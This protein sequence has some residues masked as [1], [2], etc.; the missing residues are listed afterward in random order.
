MPVV[1]TVTQSGAAVTVTSTNSGG[2][3]ST[4]LSA[5][6]VAGIVIGTFLG[7]VLLIA[8]VL[9]LLNRYSRHK[10]TRVANSAHDRVSP[11]AGAPD[12]RHLPGASPRKT[13]HFTR[14]A[15]RPSMSSEPLISPISWPPLPSTS[16]VQSPGTPRSAD[17]I[18]PG[19]RDSQYSSYDLGEITQVIASGTVSHP[20]VPAILN[21]PPA[22]K[23]GQT[24]SGS[25]RSGLGDTPL[26]ARQA[27]AGDIPGPF[28][29]QKPQSNLFIHRML[30][31]RAQASEGVPLPHSPSLDLSQSRSTTLDSAG[32]RVDE[33]RLLA[34]AER[35]ALRDAEIAQRNEDERM[36]DEEDDWEEVGT[37]ESI[38]S[39]LSAPIDHSAFFSEPEP[40]SC[41]NSSLSAPRRKSSRR[42]TRT[43]AP[44]TELPPV[45]EVPDN[46]RS[47]EGQS[48]SRHVSTAANSS[49]DGR[50]SHGTASRP[51][52][53]VIDQ[54]GTLPLLTSVTFGNST[55]S[56][57]PPG[58]IL[59]TAGWGS[60]SSG[61]A[62]RYPSLTP[63]STGW[64]SQSGPRSDT[65]TD[66]HHPPSGL[67]GL[68][69]LQIGP[70][71][72]PHSPV[73][74]EPEQADV[75][76]TPRP[77]DPTPAKRAHLRE[78]TV[79]SLPEVERRTVMQGGIAH[80]DVA[81]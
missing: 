37:T 11:A 75:L 69:S 5:G 12:L 52:S 2:V 26:H 20:A 27:S 23:P 70:L 1:V 56:N 49:L 18:S 79:G 3:S 17:S 43:P 41:Q 77:A 33:E 72:N 73:Q 66:W 29:S 6:T 80:I 58:S 48:V 19:I 67:A 8:L 62:S 57:T 74:E 7:G 68:T 34:E 36:P 24:S 38:Y 32:F 42:Q 21:I 78:G 35:T 28:T 46:P 39:Q 59:S 9:Y 60:S 71:R 53:S 63:S 50:V 40:V 81:L 55:K 10:F 47:R 13:K 44:L 31:S 15:Q 64:S 4:S 54:P 61:K 30:Q 51:M 45:T 14:H 25:L 16:R 65:G 76:F 22:R